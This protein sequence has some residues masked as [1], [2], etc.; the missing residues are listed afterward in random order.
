MAAGVIQGTEQS[1]MAMGVIEETVQEP[2]IEAAE[3]TLGVDSTIIPMAPTLAPPGD[4]VKRNNL[5]I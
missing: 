5:D 4:G 1:S 2:M 3:A